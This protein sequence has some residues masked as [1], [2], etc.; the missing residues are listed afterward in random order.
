MGQYCSNWI[1]YL[2]AEINATVGDSC[3]YEITPTRYPE[4]KVELTMNAVAPIEQV[5]TV[6]GFND[7]LTLNSSDVDT[8]KEFSFL[9]V[10]WDI[11]SLLK[12]RT[13][14]NIA[15]IEIIDDGNG[16]W[17]LKIT[18]RRAGSTYVYLETY[19]Y[20]VYGTFIL[21]VEDGNFALADSTLSV[22]PNTTGSV[23]VTFLPAGVWY[24]DIIVESDD[25]S[26][27]TGHVNIINGR[28]EIVITGADEGTCEIACS[29][30]VEGVTQQQIIAVTVEETTPAA[31]SE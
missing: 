15:D 6:T 29:L 14:D 2:A 4:Y 17:H 3:V 16:D 19:S 10:D 1:I 28:W 5:S 18:P 31:P 30:T 7:S 24:W 26:V 13:P 11:E 22:E 9:P 20:A 21:T 23:D 12:A 25:D 27:A 8:S